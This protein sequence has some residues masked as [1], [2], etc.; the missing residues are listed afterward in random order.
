M[1][2]TRPA[3]AELVRRFADD[4]TVPVTCRAIALFEDGVPIALGGSYIQNGAVVLF[5]RATDQG[6]KRKKSL[7]KAARDFASRYKTVCAYCDMD[8]EGADRF[9]RHLGM[10][11]ME[12]D[13]WRRG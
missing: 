6:R 2:E 1:I 3:T 11:H 4:G 8:I 10:T 13:I 5:M 12:N 9:L 7:F